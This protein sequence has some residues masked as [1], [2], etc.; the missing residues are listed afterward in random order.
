MYRRGGVSVLCVLALVLPSFADEP[1]S[2]PVSLGITVQSKDLAD[3]RLMPQGAPSLKSRSCVVVSSVDPSGPCAEK[4]TDG[5]AIISIDG[6]PT[7]DVAAYEKALKSLKPGTE[8]AIK[9]L[10]LAPAPLGEKKWV[11]GSVV[12]KVV[13]TPPRKEVGEAARRD[14]AG[15]PSSGDQTVASPGSTK[16]APKV[17]APPRTPS[18]HPEPGQVE[19][20]AAPKPEVATSK[21]AARDSDDDIVNVLIGPT[22]THYTK[23]GYKDVEFGSGLDDLKARLSLASCGEFQALCPSGSERDQEFYFTA[24]KQLFCYVKE[25]QGGLAE[26][27]EDLLK[28]FGRCTKDFVG[29]RGDTVWANFDYVF[30]K[31]VVRVQAV[32]ETDG[33]GRPQSTTTIIVIDRKWFATAIEKR[34]A[35]LRKCV[36]WTKSCQKELCLHD[37]NANSDWHPDPARVPDVPGCRATICGE[38]TAHSRYGLAY[39]S[40]DRGIECASAI[41]LDTESR[42]F[43]DERVAQ[44][45][46]EPIFWPGYRTDRMFLDLPEGQDPQEFNDDALAALGMITGFY[47]EAVRMYLQEAFPPREKNIRMQGN[48]YSWETSDKETGDWDIA[49]GFNGQTFGFSATKKPVMRKKRL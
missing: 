19:P 5:N 28:V 24:D 45:N 3:A 49:A 15:S 30:P 35:F 4:L 39:E 11:P 20:P 47:F 43:P 2:P 42:E 46:C 22:S 9:G 25:Y 48:R 37:L 33:L 1:E 18:A 31:V 16:P 13:A 41:A 40:I 6:V 26:Y 32:T 21:P 8:I 38:K 27:K 34:L 17:A 12:V 44:V 36:A 10:Y 23:Y 29:N 7:P 14:V